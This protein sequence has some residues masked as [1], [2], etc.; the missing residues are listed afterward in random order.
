MPFGLPDFFKG[1]K[2]SELVTLSASSLCSAAEKK[3]FPSLAL[4]V[5]RRAEVDP[6]A[7]G[8]S[9]H[10]VCLHCP[11]HKPAASLTSRAQHATAFVG[12]TRQ[13]SSDGESD[14]DSWFGD[15]DTPRSSPARRNDRRKNRMRLRLGY[16]L[17]IG[18]KRL[19]RAD[20]GQ[21][22]RRYGR[23][24]AQPSL[25]FSPGF[26][27]GGLPTLPGTLAREQD[28]GNISGSE[29]SGACSYATCNVRHT[30]CEPDKMSR[31]AHI[32]RRKCD[33]YHTATCTI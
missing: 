28:L 9:F 5:Q 11:A 10:W 22:R 21:S 32:V 26:G 12:L 1:R 27:A 23:V 31:A 13:G 17:S 16:S 2:L 7:S 6:D 33:S 30:R 14:K 15:A 24:L 25:R 18:L 19:P 4:G 8:D 3:Q 29:G 20:A